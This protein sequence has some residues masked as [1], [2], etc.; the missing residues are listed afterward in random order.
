MAGIACAVGR[1]KVNGL[2]PL[3]GK[4]VLIT[5]GT[6]SLGKTLVKRLLT[7]EMGRPAKICVF[8]RDE[9]K[10][11]FMRLE[12]QRLKAATDEL[13]DRDF[14]KVLEFRIGDVRDFGSVASVLRSA[15]VVIN[16]A[17]MKQAPTCEYFPVEAVRT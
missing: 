7:G 10:Q 2:R 3:E 13:I 1:R 8:S 9:A 16:A 14:E 6:G 11:Y 17:A 12:H 5:G 4:R 15:D